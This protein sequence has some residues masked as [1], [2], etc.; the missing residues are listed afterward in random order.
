MS[1]PELSGNPSSS[2]LVVKQEELMKEMNFVL[3]SISFVL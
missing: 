3:R 2:R 1:R